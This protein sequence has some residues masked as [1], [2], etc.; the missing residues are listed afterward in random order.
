MKHFLLV[1]DMQKEFVDGQSSL[2]ETQNDLK[3]ASEK[4]IESTSSN[5]E[6]LQSPCMYIFCSCEELS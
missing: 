6:T 2:A 3:D 4:V 1:V 5:E